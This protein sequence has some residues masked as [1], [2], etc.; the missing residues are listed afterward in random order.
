MKKLILPLVFLFVLFSGQSAYSQDTLT[1][2]EAIEDL[3][4]DFVPDRLDDTV[5][6]AGVV[7]SPNFQTTNN[8]FYLWDG[9]AGVD[10]FMFG[11]PTFTWSL[12]DSLIITG[13]VAQF[14]GMTEI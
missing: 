7:T 5:T 9:T 4:A 3:D 13:T 11:P 14:S 10:L 2:A 6:V 8:S 1:I 12:G